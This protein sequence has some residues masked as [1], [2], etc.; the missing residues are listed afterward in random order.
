LRPALALLV[1]AP[2][3]LAAAGCARL[4]NVGRPPE[5][6]APGRPVPAVA[7]IAPERIALATPRPAPAPGAYTTGSL[8]RNGPES[9]FGD[10]RAQTQGDLVTV[11]I[12]IDDGAQISNATTRNRTG[13]EELSV[14]ALL[15]LP[16]VAEAI[17]PAGVGLDPAASIDSTSSSTGD[18]TV[19]RTE[20]IT[21][22]LAATVTGV[23]PN[24]HLVIAGAQEV[25]VNYELRELQVAGIVRPE[26]ITRRN[27][28]TYD[29][30]AEARIL[31]G[32]RGQITDVQQP[33]YGQQVADILLPF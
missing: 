15:G 6:T 33:R 9:L 7:P 29:R 23:L 2:A 31:Y 27:E 18:G 16:S 32:G 20:K 3:I 4:E 12:E 19:N 22:R 28:I 8:W 10:R 13:S 21:L 14:P 24:G 30:I 17:L 25:R 11:V 1:L 26:D 5:I